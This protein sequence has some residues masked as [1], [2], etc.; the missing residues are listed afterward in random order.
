MSTFFH[1][2]DM[3]NPAPKRKRII[4][5]PTPLIGDLLFYELVHPDRLETPEYGTAH[6]DTVRWPDHKLVYVKPIDEVGDHYQYWYAADRATQ[7]LYNFEFRPFSIAGFR[8]DS[9]VRTY[10]NPREDF[11]NLVPA[12]ASTMPDL[13]AGMFTGEWIL[14]DIQQK[15]GDEI[16][17]SLYVVEE[18]VYIQRYTNKEYTYDD[19]FGA[20]LYETQYV[21][22]KDESAFDFLSNPDNLDDI[23][24]EALFDAPDNAAWGLQENGKFRGGARLNDDWYLLFERDTVPPWMVDDGR[25]Y[26]TTV[27]FSWPAVLGGITMDVWPL[28]SGGQ[29]IYPRVFLSRE[30]YRGATRAT[31]F[32]QFFK[33]A[34]TGEAELGLHEVLNP[35]PLQFSCPFFSLSVGPTLHVGDSITITTGTTHPKYD[36]AGDTWDFDASNYTDW[37]ESMIASD[38]LKPFRGGFLREQVTVYRP[39]FLEP[40]P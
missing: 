35:T 5:Q 7:D 28:R 10:L 20:P 33:D 22:H 9:V 11:D 15:R 14:F 36:Y 32:Q 40:P 30:S 6:P 39:E 37:P 16:L 19:F 29:E 27:D 34:A 1:I 21:C 38:E 18:R 13:P 23:T 8:L 12:S 4:N 17:D 24:I 3:L 31:V 26:D 2:S 25:S